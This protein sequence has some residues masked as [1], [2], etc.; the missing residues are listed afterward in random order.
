VACSARL[1]AVVVAEAEEVVVVPVA[2]V[3]LA[4]RMNRTTRT[5]RSALALWLVVERGL[6]ALV[7]VCRYHRTTTTRAAVA[8]AALALVSPFRRTTRRSAEPAVPPEV[9]PVKVAV[10][11][12]AV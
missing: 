9:V 1:V 11:V 8:L 7:L 4:V 6:A 10:T 2:L 12:P 5:E 3:G